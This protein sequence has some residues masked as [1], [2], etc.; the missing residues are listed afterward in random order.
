MQLHWEPRPLPASPPS[1][2]SPADKSLA[3]ASDEARASALRP[4]KALD[5]RGDMT[6]F[7][8]FL[9]V[10][11]SFEDLNSAAELRGTYLVEYSVRASLPETEEEDDVDEAAGDPLQEVADAYKAKLE[12]GETSPADAIAV[13]SV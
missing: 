9:K 6:L 3:E 7:Q 1:D 4:E 8:A 5:L 10:R 12:S 2:A 11:K 13:L